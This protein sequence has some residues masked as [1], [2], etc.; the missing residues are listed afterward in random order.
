MV[1]LERG[2]SAGAEHRDGYPHRLRALGHL[3]EA[4]DESRAWPDLHD[5]IRD[6]R[7]AYQQTGKVPDFEAMAAILASV[8]HFPDNQPNTTGE[9]V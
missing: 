1:V 7:R 2:L 5:A 8:G 9:S 4:E 3:F 6:A